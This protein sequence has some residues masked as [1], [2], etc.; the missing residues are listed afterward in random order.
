M[1]KYF[2][3]IPCIIILGCA[4][5]KNGGSYTE[6]GLAA[7]QNGELNYAQ[8]LFEQA[9]KENPRD[10]FTLNNL[11]VVHERRGNYKKALE[12]YQAAAQTGSS[13]TIGSDDPEYKGITISE[14]AAKNAKRAREI[15]PTT[16]PGQSKEDELKGLYSTAYKSFT[17]EEYDKALYEF[18]RYLDLVSDKS[19]AGNALYWIGEIYYQ[20]EDY[21]QSLE[22]FWKVV[23]DYPDGSKIPDTLLRLGDTYKALE[24]RQS[25]ARMFKKVI[26][27]FP[28]TDAAKKAEKRLAGL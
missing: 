2:I 25:A 9:L 16:V 6:K 17:S 5:T 3:L 26:E 7:L 18:S 21:F 28:N 1:K 23:T 11:G 14:L 22:T 10:S 24:D 4:T 13:V 8:A 20:K 19:L 15:Q 27:S 12:M